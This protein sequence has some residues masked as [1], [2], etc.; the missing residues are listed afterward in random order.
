MRRGGEGRRERNESHLSYVLK[1]AR[2]LMIEALKPSRQTD[3]RVYFD[4]Y[5]RS[6]RAVLL[7]IV[8]VEWVA[9]LRGYFLGVI[10]S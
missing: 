10:F 2:M 9:F 7:H 4:A 5:N 6:M 3:V 8:Y 1:R